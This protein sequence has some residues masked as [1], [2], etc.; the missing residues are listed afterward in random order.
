MIDNIM[1]T[2]TVV[3]VIIG[4]GVVVVAFLQDYTD[5]NQK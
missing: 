2:G 5:T 3:L 4:I 1:I